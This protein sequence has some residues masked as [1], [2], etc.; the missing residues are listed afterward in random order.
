MKIDV[1]ENILRKAAADDDMDAFVQ[2]FVDAINKAIGGELTNE[3][4]PL[5]NSDQTTLLGWSYLHTEVMD[6]GY[7][8][9]IYNGYGR[10][11]F[12]NPFSAAVREWGLPELCSH[13]RHAKKYYDKYHSQIER[14][15]TD[16]E[17]MALYE[18]M[19]E[20]DEYDDEFITNEE[21]W[22]RQIAEYI[23]GHIGQ[24]TT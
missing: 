9:L 23:D 14:D 7:V 5:L 24:F 20:F 2:A 19:P 3:N 17:F 11:I 16:D 4:L 8:Q 13:V 15:M 21:Q 1:D 10:F 6:G 12:R 22:T 18:Q